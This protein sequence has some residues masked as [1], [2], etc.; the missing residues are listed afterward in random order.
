MFA[1]FSKTPHT[2]RSSHFNQE[3][4]KHY[5]FLLGGQKKTCDEPISRSGGIN[6]SHPINTIREQAPGF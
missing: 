1:P 5:Q 6:V 4:M 3:N 2:A